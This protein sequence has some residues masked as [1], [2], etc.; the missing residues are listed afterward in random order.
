MGT[1]QDDLYEN[2]RDPDSE[3]M[4]LGKMIT[5]AL[6]V[7]SSL[8]AFAYVLVNVI[9]FANCSK[10]CNEHYRICRDLMYQPAPFNYTRPAIWDDYFNVSGEHELENEVG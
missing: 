2:M 1:E 3:N 9:D 10:A 4:K 8:M 5:K 7:G 6:I